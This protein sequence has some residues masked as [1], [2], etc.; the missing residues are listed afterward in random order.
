MLRC[1]RLS[2]SC[3]LLCAWLAGMALLARGADGEEEQED[4]EEEGVV[5]YDE[6]C[7]EQP[8]GWLARYGLLRH[9]A[10]A[11]PWLHEPVVDDTLVA[12][13]D[14]ETVVDVSF[15]PHLAGPGWDRSWTIHCTREGMLGWSCDPPE[16]ATFVYL[17]EGESAVPIGDDISTREALA[18]LAIVVI[19]SSGPG[20]ADPFDASE[21]YR[22]LTPEAVLSVT[23]EEFCRGATV[24]IQI[25]DEEPKLQL[26]VESVPCAATQ[27]PCPLS[28]RV[29]GT[30][31]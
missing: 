7:D 26:C 30:V 10:H 5:A 6:D 11:Y 14:E 12:C 21:P 2:V 19:Q 28:A 3:A 17:S 1:R 22:D 27:A 23:R 9:L 20:I 15:E 4:Q 29:Q 25:D 18:A 24:T 13:A 8:L 16:D 31:E